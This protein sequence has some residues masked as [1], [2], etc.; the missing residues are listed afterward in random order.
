MFS[1]YEAHEITNNLLS[2][3]LRP[4]IV[5]SPFYRAQQNRYFHLKTGVKPAP[6]TLWSHFRIL[7]DGSNPEKQ[8]H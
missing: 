4:E 3:L 1:A 6:E 8:Q 7:N 5:K 2:I